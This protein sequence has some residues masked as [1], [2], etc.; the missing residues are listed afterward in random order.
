MNDDIIRRG[1]R[2]ALF[3]W[4]QDDSELDDLTNDLW[5]WYLERPGTQ[6]KMAKLTANEA[7][8]TVKL[9]ALQMLSGKQ[10]LSNEFNGRNLYSSDSVREALRGESTNRYLVDILPR[11]MEALAAQNERQAE[12]IRVRYDDGIVPPADSAEAAMLKR[13]VKSLTEQVNVIA[14]TAGVD[15]DGN[16][17]EGPGSRHSVFPETRPTSGGHS[18]P[19]ADIAILLIEHPELRDEYLYEPSLPEFLGGRC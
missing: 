10:L 12:S 7:V 8:E 16:V 17:T 14:I 13:A 15:A 5:V 6:R 2:K 9:A 19:T 11:A 3:A 4:K 1:A 18:D